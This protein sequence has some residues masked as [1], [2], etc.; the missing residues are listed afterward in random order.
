[1]RAP[2]T[3]NRADL[4]TAPIGDPG[5]PTSDFEENLVLRE[6]LA[7]AHERIRQ[8]EAHIENLTA[9]VLTPK[10][11]DRR[12]AQEPHPE[13]RSGHDRRRTPSSGVQVLRDADAAGGPSTTALAD[14]WRTWAPQLG[15][16]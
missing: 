1:M 2:P 4:G 6:L 13:R 16:K 12:R 10:P 8:L 15:K 9:A 11:G 7:E 3:G 5:M 14:F